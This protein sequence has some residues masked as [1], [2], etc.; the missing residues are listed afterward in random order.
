MRVP[1]SEGV[2]PD[3]LG[4]VTDQEERPRLSSSESGV[5]TECQCQCPDAASGEGRLSLS[6]P[7]LVR[8]G[9]GRETISSTSAGHAMQQET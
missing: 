7:A 4:L 2:G 5:R 6:A 1:W 9:C 8:A 3:R